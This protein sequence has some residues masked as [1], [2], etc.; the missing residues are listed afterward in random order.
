MMVEIWLIQV[1]PTN[2]FYI[3]FTLNVVAPYTDLNSPVYT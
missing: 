3:S 1:E 2:R